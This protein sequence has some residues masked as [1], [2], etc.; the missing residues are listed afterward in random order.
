MKTKRRG[1]ARGFESQTTTLEFDLRAI[2]A[3]DYTEDCVVVFELLG[4]STAMP[5]QTPSGDLQTLTSVLASLFEF[6]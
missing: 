1:Q 2:S 3:K 5:Y 4:T 6:T